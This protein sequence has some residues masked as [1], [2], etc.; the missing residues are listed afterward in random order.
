MN[1]ELKFNGYTAQPSDYE[2]Q[3]GDLAAVLN[4]MPEKGAMRPVTK[5]KSI[6]TLQSDREEVSF[7]HTLTDGSRNVIT[8]DSE[9]DF[10]WQKIGTS[11]RTMLWGAGGTE[12]YQ[13]SAI[14]ST[15]CFLSEDG[16]VYKIWKSSGQT[17]GYVHLGNAFPECK[18][19]FGLQAEFAESDIYT[20]TLPSASG[21]NDFNAG[22]N[23]FT[24]FSENNS[25]AITESVLA[26][27]NK[28]I[29]EK[30]SGAGKFIMPFFV[31]YAYRLYDGSLTQHSAPILMLAASDVTPVASIRGTVASG[32]TSISYSICAAVHNLDY[33][34]DSASLNALDDWKDIIKSVDVFV[35]APLYWYN[36]NA[37]IERVED[38]NDFPHGWYCYCKQ[39]DQNLSTSLFPLRYQRNTLSRLAAM[40]SNGS[41]PYYWTNGTHFKLPQYSEEDFVK[42]IQSCH[43]FYLLKSLEAKNMTANTRTLITVSNDYLQS[44]TSREAMTDDY[45]SHDQLIPEGAFVYNS[46][47]NIYGIS[48]KLFNGFHPETMV[49]FTNGYIAPPKWII[50]HEH[51]GG[52]GGGST[53][54]T[55]DIDED[56]DYEANDTITKFALLFTYKQEGISAQLY[57]GQASVGYWTSIDFIY[58]PSTK[59]KSVIIY[60]E[61]TS[62][63]YALYKEEKDMVAHE[64]LNGSFFY[65]PNN[66]TSTYTSEQALPSSGNNVTID[67]QNK[68]YTSEI[69]NPF[70]FPLLGINTVG[71]GKIVGLSTAAK[72]LSQGQFGQFPMY[73]FTTDGVWALEVS[74]TTGAFSA[75]QPI[76]RDVCINPASI[77][78][79]DSA[80]LF[81]TDR[82]IML[83]SGSQTQCITDTVDNDDEPFKFSSL[84]L[85]GNIKTLLGVSSGSTDEL[86]EKKF[87]L[88]LEDCQMLYAYNRQAIIVF[89]RYYGN[90]SY[91]YSLESKQWGKIPGGIIN[92]ITSYPEAYAFMSNHT[93]VDF[94]N[95]E[96]SMDPAAIQIYP[97]QFL[98][99]RPLK[100]DPS[101]KDVNKTIDNIIARGNFQKGHVGIV[102]YGSRDLINWFAIATSADHYL[103]GFR[104]TP[105]KY[106]RIALVCSLTHKESVWGCSIQYTPRLAN[107][108]R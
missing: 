40:K 53:V 57:A 61:P 39:T 92:R 45:D 104:G 59:I 88:F 68:I 9:G 20:V 54:T 98:V 106:F 83:I 3:D 87:S 15:L 38:N 35:S 85:S 73:A 29:A 108:P 103:R 99:T 77:T 36:Q 60:R 69:Q 25:N 2:C 50:S 6:Q 84:P 58:Y 4:L 27:V 46:R 95:E 62:R 22:T 5:P 71:S 91:V 43:A 90:S 37:K 64:F 33:A 19:T 8:R 100:L 102:L 31:R 10:Y 72:A 48:K 81:A 34:I 14:G 89:S 44:L 52:Q 76:T 16:I 13:V 96:V 32:D 86:L 18:L 28:F 93:I 7:I 26:K 24:A 66:N 47:L 79:I 30:G 107:Q 101:L 51:E 11:T 75:K 41:R 82:G 97:K 105:Y 63:D 1:Q 70:F 23:G 12:C 94:S 74:A 56:E 80:V 17:Q 65:L 67:I 21:A 49:A 78:Q 42:S 55:Y